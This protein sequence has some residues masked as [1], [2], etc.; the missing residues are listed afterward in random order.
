MPTALPRRG[1]A[2]ALV[3]SLVTTVLSATPPS[4]VAAPYTPPVP[5]KE[6][7]IK[8]KTAGAAKN[9]D[10]RTGKA[11]TA[12][13]PVWPR[14]TVAEVPL[15][16]SASKVVGTPL[17]VAAADGTTTERAAKP[18]VRIETFDREK[19]RKAG[20]EGLLFKVSGGSAKV[21]VDYSS[22]RWA[23]G[24]DWSSRLRLVELPECALSTPDKPECAAKPVGSRNDTAKSKVT[25]TQASPA[26]ATF[27]ALT[28]G[29]SSGSGSYKATSLSPSATWAAGSNTGGFSWNYPLRIPPSLGGPTPSL[30]LAYSSASVDGRMAASNNQPSWIGEGFDLGTNFIERKYIGCASD[31]ADGARNTTET[32][33][34]CWRNENATLS[35]TGHGGELIKEAG[36]SNRWRLRNDDG[37]RVEF[38]TGANNGAR[39]GEHWVVTTKDGTQYWFGRGSQSVLNVPVAGNHAGEPCAAALFKDSFCAQPW[40]WNLEYVVDTHDNTMTYSYDKET[41][42]YGRNSSRTDVVEYD[43][44]SVLKQIDYGTRADRT[45][46]AP[47]QVVLEPADRCLADCGTKDAAHW[48]DTPWDQE[49]T[50]SP[51]NYSSPTFWGT[52]RL[53][54]VTTK[55]GGNA[56]EK[57]TLTHSFPDPGDGTRAGLWLDKIS[58]AGLVGQQ[59]TVPDV[60]F[61]GIQLSNRVDTHSDQLAAMKWW[62]LKTIFTESGGKIDVT[63]SAPD[64][65]PGSRMPAVNA[66]QDNKLRCYPVRWTPPG[67]LTPIW[68]FF[69]KY[70]VDSMTESDLTGGSV[71]VLTQYE[72]LGD[73]AWH[74]TDD[75]GFVK[76]EDKTWSMWRGYGA[77]R[78]RL[79]DPGEQTLTERRYFRGMHGDKMPSGTREETLPAISVGNVESVNDEDAFAGLLREEIIYNGPGG[80]EVSATVTGPWRSEPTATRT[81]N[82]VTVDARYVQSARKH[83]RVALDSGRGFRTTTQVTDFDQTYGQATQTEDRGDDAVTGDE[84]CVLI[85]YV[86]NTSAWVTDKVSRKRD[87]LVDCAKA[88]PG[89]DLQDSDIAGDLKNYY[90]GQGHGVAPTKGDPTRSDTLKSYANATPAYLTESST[91]RDVYGRVTKLTD[92]KGTLSTAY[93]PALGGPVTEIATTNTLGWATKTAVE[94]AWGSPVSTTDPNDQKA[95]IEY[96]GLGRTTAVWKPG[97]EKAGRPAYKKFT[98][99]ER[100]DQPSVVTS[101]VMINGQYVASREFYDGLLRPR[102][103]QQPN[104]S[105]GTSSTVVTD[106]HY[107]S[108]GRA[109]RANNAYEASVAPSD[110]LFVPT[111]TI[112]AATTTQYDGAGREI[113]SV[114][115]KN[116]PVASPGGDELFRTTTY[117]AGDRTD[118][119]PPAGGVVTSTL[120]DAQGRKSE[121]RQYHAGVVAG[122]ATGFDATK[123]TYDRKGQL[124]EVAHPSGKKWQYSYDTRGRQT[125]TVDPDKGRTESSYDDAD[126]LVSTKD[127]RGQVLAHTYDA[128]GRKT[129]TRDDS[130]TGPARLEWFYDLLAS[131]IS[132]KGAQ[133]KSVRHDALGDYVTEHKRMRPW[134]FQPTSTDITIP[135]GETGLGGTYNYVYSY[136]G[137]AQLLSTR[138]PAVGDLKVETL[139]YEYDAL[140][141]P[142]NQSSGYGT[143]PLTGLVTSTTYT[144]LGELATYELRNGDSA[145]ANWVSV[146][147]DY[148]DYTRRLT[149]IWTT[150]LTG[151]TDVANVSYSHDWAGNVTKVSDSVSAD[152]QCFRADHLRRLTE[153][154]TPASGNCA[155]DPTVAGLGGPSKYWQSYTYNVAGDR[156]KLVEHG[157]T[158]GDRTTDYTLTPGKHSVAKTVTTDNAGSRQATYTYD[159][160]G[161]T[162]TRPSP[163]GATQTMTWDRE[164]HV[165]ATTDETGQ[166][167]YVYD[168]NGNRL[169]RRDPAGR[170]L[171]LPG[172]ELRYATPAATKSATRY[173][174]HAGQSI[175]M[176]T[177]T[178]ITWMTSDQHGTAQ[179]TITASSQT[180]STRRTTPFGEVRGNTGIWPAKLDKGFVGGTLDNT[181]LTHIGAREYDPK[182]G[183]FISVDPIMDLAD[184]RQWNAY[185]YANNSPVTF[186][187]PTGL[188]CDS[189]NF[190]EVTK[191]ESSDAGD[192]VGCGYSTN[193]LCGPTG[194]GVSEQDH[195]QEQQQQYEWASGTGDG[196]N[197]PIIY[198]HRLPTAE[199]MKRGPIFGAQVMMAPGETYADAVKNWATYLCRSSNPGAGFCEWSETVG[200]KPA[201]GWDAVFVILGAVGLAA[202]GVGGSAA[203]QAATSSKGTSSLGNA[204]KAAEGCNSFT[205]DTQVL[206]ADDTTKRIDEIQLGDQ[207][208][209]A[210][211]ETGT[212]GAREVEATIIGEG[213]K[214]L[215]EIVTADGA[216]TATDGHPF[217]L[218][219][220][221]RWVDAKDLRE[222]SDLQT[223]TGGRLRVVATKIWVGV[224]RVHNLTVEGIHT[225][226]V[227]L[228][229]QN[230]LVHNTGPCADLG[231]AWKAAPAS[232]I[233]CSTGCEKVAAGIQAKIGGEVKTIQ[234]DPGRR[235]QLGPYRGQDSGWFSHTVVVRE[236]RVYDGFSPRTGVPVDEYKKLFD[237]HDVIDFG[238]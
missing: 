179:N 110:S 152:T 93:T 137:D 50:G 69:H 224:K 78:T 138:I 190:Y 187:D 199:E 81:I 213:V 54:A 22:F 185:V 118:T 174:A 97:Q 8:G 121:L 104:A 198:G 119:T 16:A 37:T 155:P 107:D 31:M 47:M 234:V 98:Y 232:S 219:G 66:L 209:A 142:K 158:A 67:D 106:I 143:T 171:Y 235:F 95:F 212:S 94:P 140:G 88:K 17:A 170:T 148:D 38:R 83:T 115:K 86:R 113:I 186:S 96:D 194:S 34:M 65:V 59:T 85:D 26:T 192:W 2:V 184:P 25:A 79:G 153:A 176:R 145:G 35:M 60:R 231:P 84:K 164:G 124:T 222:G 103:T 233:P 168:A 130:P 197:Q 123:Y 21:E 109:K 210:D 172:Q 200:N 129:S 188:Y 70:V 149:Q 80:A 36:E 51:C 132:I 150:K 75:D 136:N 74:Y 43:R 101:S 166:S 175:A 100:I 181:G 227:R 33:D 19:T 169:V 30:T 146:L 167:S 6:R 236:G 215:V 128:L 182:L 108:A 208:L 221:Q 45:E 206:M 40:R 68:D 214:F 207:V 56:V 89:T 201:N 42:K 62:R 111:D 165:A 99:L 193:G 229:S 13:A 189:C 177:S 53:A 112:L 203:K 120:L 27:M 195:Q 180:V 1:L 64:C 133:V 191:G 205:G 225:Y 114:L 151:P 90:D 173:Y 157:T 122:A 48:P 9:E 52:K 39:N 61:L 161:N 204:I 216:I 24:A 202:G 230:V 15:G 159:N 125:V 55:V 32:G 73:P 102:Q 223:S 134:D 139:Q 211:P 77:V 178:G 58:R 41:N 23:Y 44:A 163:G 49:C 238:F 10:V 57:W 228:G 237:Y 154:W 183:R 141:K 4:A 71:R 5:A 126:Q 11:F 162:L 117:Y 7:V 20:V 226:F 135:A 18:K 147:R 91:E 127:A 72:Y 196:S 29:T 131:G 160:A 220:E 63:Y 46:T 3:A 144:P 116:A 28:A 92:P 76:A 156:T 12:G 82:G 105:G 217:W 87:Y 14:P 218:P